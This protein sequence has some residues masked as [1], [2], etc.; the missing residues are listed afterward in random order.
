MPII[1]TFP[2]GRKKAAALE[3]ARGIITDL[4]KGAGGNF[5]GSADIEPGVKGVLPLSNGGTGV[6]DIEA[7]KK[8]L[9]LPDIVAA[10]LGVSLVLN[11]NTWEQISMVS[12]KG[13]G[14]NIWSVGDRKA[15]E[16]S[17]TLDDLTMDNTYW[18][19]I[20]GFDHNKELEGSGIHFGA[21]KSAQTGGLDIALVDRCYINHMSPGIICFTMNHWGESGDPWFTNYGGWRACDL[22]YDVLGSVSAAPSAYGQMKTTDV[23]GYDAGNTT[24]TSP[25]AN[26]VMAALPIELRKVMKCVTKYTDNKGNSSNARSN[27]TAS[28]DYLPFMS[29]YE[30]YGKCTYANPY[31]Q[32]YQKQYAYYAMG[33]SK[34]KKA[35][36][37]TRTSVSWWTRSPVASSA[38]SFVMVG[39]DGNAEIG[40]TRRSYGASPVFVV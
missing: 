9:G 25:V 29:E 18:V 15:V 17:G 33:N 30:I 13:M 8:S 3:T 34:V 40:I 16:I 2:Y 20:I 23:R 39:S 37:D 32:E 10:A 31:E 38:G 26:T 1:S 4:G 28:M 6:S 14:A 11:D 19:Y 5:D 22:R 12:Q 21:F 27:V 24:A 35:G 36:I 7:L